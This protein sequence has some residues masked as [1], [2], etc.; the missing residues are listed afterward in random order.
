[1]KGF[2]DNDIIEIV[3][4]NKYSEETGNV[5]ARLFNLMVANELRG[6]CHASASVLFVCFTEL[7]FNP[8]LFI[9]EANIENKYFDHS[10]IC[11]NDK[12][13][14]LAVALPLDYSDAVG[15]VILDYDLYTKD[16]TAV[17]YGN[18]SGFEYDDITK[19]IINFNFVEYMDNAPFSENGLWE[20]VKIALNKNINIEK[21]RL[22]YQDVKRCVVQNL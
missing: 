3:K 10:W 16:K 1:M 9:G 17:K 11:L 4:M 5:I 14:D 8:E 13:I 2:I 6:F 12:I 18:K 21:M 15:P 22:T 19:N 7:G 20:F